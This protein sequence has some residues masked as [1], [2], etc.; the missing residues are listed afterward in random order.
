MAT[1][2]QIQDK[3]VKKKVKGF[4]AYADVWHTRNI[5]RQLT[6]HP[7][8]HIEYYNKLGIR[9]SLSFSYETKEK[10]IDNII[11]MLMDIRMSKN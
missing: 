4:R 5:R 7:I 2:T 3:Y 11:D 8:I 6:K 1:L 10:E 9:S